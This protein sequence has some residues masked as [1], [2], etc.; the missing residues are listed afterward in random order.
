MVVSAAIAVWT[1]K[2]VKKLI[3]LSPVLGLFCE[4]TMLARQDVLKAC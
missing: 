1:A 3:E 4:A 2:L